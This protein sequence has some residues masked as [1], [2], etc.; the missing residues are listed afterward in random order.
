M[1]IV[2]LLKATSLTFSL[3]KSTKLYSGFELEDLFI[4]PQRN[5]YLFSSTNA[6][7]ENDEYIFCGF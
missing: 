5:N 4:V 7:W 2:N 3:I 6:E 1:I